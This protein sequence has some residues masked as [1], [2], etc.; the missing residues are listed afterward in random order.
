M[1]DSIRCNLYFP[2]SVIAVADRL[3]AE[4]GLSRKALFVRALG[5]LQA[6][7]EGSRDG[8]HV[9]LSRDREKLDTILIWPI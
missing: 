8:M 1:S 7:H 2:S 3:A 9:G 6:L 4:Q 5:V